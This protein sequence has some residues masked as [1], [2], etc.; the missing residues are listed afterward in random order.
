MAMVATVQADISPLLDALGAGDRAR[1][2]QQ[3]LDLLGPRGVPPAHIAARVAI[4]A[5]W[6]GGDGHALVTLG[7]AGRV[8]E[9]MRAIPAGPEPGADT[10]RQLAPALPLVQGMMAVADR[11]GPGLREPHPALP[12]P[13]TPLEIS[14]E[15]IEGGVLGA[16]RAA[17]AARD[18]Q[19]YAGILMGFYRTGTDYRA[20]LANLYATL[21]YR[22]P[23]GAH[24]LIFATG[25]S[26]V[27]DMADWGDRVPPFIHW[28]VPLVVTDEPDEPF[29]AAARAFGEAPENGL[30]WVRTR[31]ASARE[32]AAGA[33]FRQS[34]G[35]GDATAACAAVLKALKDGAS[36]RGVASGL[37]L[38]AAE[39]LLT[40]PTG[41][42]DALARAA[43][44]LLYAHAVH[45]V[46]AQSQ[47]PD[48]YPVLYTA[49]AAVNALPL[50]AAPAAASPTSTPLAGGLIAPA[51]LRSLEHQ[52]ATGDAQSALA[53]A[54]RY[55]QMNHAP[56]SLA[57]ILGA[58]AAR[59]DAPANPH[60]LAAVAA[61]AE[62]YLTQPGAG[63]L[64]FSSATASQS[65]LLGATIRLA[66]EL[67][68]D[69]ALAQQVEAGIAARMAGQ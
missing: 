68:G 51:L 11:V 36:T 31:L 37:A 53:T 41:D 5:A 22:C 58:A 60:G 9:W 42:A 50:G 29:V 43:H 16:L 17:F 21:I 10:Q 35:V 26:R 59:R 25:A 27:L 2:I 8:A 56:R 45:T 15:G 13:R 46:M 1:V 48:V 38:A 28:L 19:R 52:V 33:G 47:D 64:A 39:R 55:I 23:G 34:L 14:R 4:P 69:T 66:S 12:D 20:L 40:V 54:R 44:V 63:W 18:R 32:E 6:A 49:A 62:E 65:A 30:G 3:T 7:A 67:P 61:A 24:P 57:G